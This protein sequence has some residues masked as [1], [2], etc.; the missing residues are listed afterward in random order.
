MGF[1]MAGF[2]KVA[3]LSL[4]ISQILVL[5]SLL[6]ACSKGFEKEAIQ[7]DSETG[8][9]II[10]GKN[11]DAKT[12]AV[13]STVLLFNALTKDACTATLLGNNYAL[14]AAHCIDKDNTENLYVL[15]G[16][17]REEL[18]DQRVVIASKASQYWK[19]RQREDKDTG[20][21]AVIKFEGTGL[22]EGYGPAEFLQDTSLLRNG[23]NTFVLGFGVTDAITTAGAGTLRSANLPILNSTYSGSEL[24]LDQSKGSRICHGDSGGPAYIKAYDKKTKT[25]KYYLWGIANRGIGDDDNTCE[26]AVA[27]TNVTLYLVWIQNVLKTL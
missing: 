4:K 23:A 11:V 9:F 14:T 10:N 15:F 22:P 12:P 20:D 8:Y 19:I 13:R 27:Y 18:F 17:E 5:T 3:H 16:T 1:S 26:N 6:L 24:L 2:K 25:E 21:I 7:T